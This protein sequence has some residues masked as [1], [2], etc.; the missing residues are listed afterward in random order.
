MSIGAISGGSS[1]LP[2]INKFITKEFQAADTDKSGGVSLE[3]F[4]KV[5]GPDPS[6]G[7]QGPSA[8]ESEE[9]FK[10]LDG[11]SDGQISK[12]ELATAIKDEI[13]QQFSSDTASSLLAIQEQ[14]DPQKASGGNSK[15]AMLSALLKSTQEST[16]TDQNSAAKN[17]QIDPFKAA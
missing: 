5:D 2:N 17:K 4:K 3:E 1:A 15:S 13:R 9:L 6:S 8:A 12:K 16:A 14:S 11:N 7:A 10:E